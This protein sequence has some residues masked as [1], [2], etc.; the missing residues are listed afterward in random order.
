MASFLRSERYFLPTATNH[1]T[2]LS[3]PV[4]LKSFLHTF[5]HG[6]LWWPHVCYL[7]TSLP[8]TVFSLG[9]HTQ[10]QILVWK[11]EVQ[12]AGPT[13]WHSGSAVVEERGTLWDKTGRARSLRPGRAALNNLPLQPPTEEIRAGVNT[14]ERGVA[15]LFVFIFQDSVSSYKIHTHTNSI[16]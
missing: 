7:Q 10:R 5:S 12:K 6:E 16:Q 11:E 14:Q 1:Q 4:S 13:K 9:R 15:G 2:Q 3:L 8:P